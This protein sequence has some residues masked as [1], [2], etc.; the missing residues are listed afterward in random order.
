MIKHER[1]FT[2]IPL[3]IVDVVIVVAAAVIAV[4]RETIKAKQK[5]HERKQITLTF[6]NH[7]AP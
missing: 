7:F 3:K 2:F 1:Q 6:P 5:S 4:V